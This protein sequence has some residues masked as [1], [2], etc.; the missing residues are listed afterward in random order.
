MKLLGEN[1]TEAVLQALDRLN[2][3]DAR[4]TAS[5]TLEVVYELMKNMKVVLDGAWRVPSPWFTV[6]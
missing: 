1:E 3:D 2:H 6:P 4:T 5:L